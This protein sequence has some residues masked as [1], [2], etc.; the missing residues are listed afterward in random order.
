[1]GELGGMR[2]G[3]GPEAVAHTLSVTVK[4]GT[5]EAEASVS[6]A[7]PAAEFLPASRIVAVRDLLEEAMDAFAVDA[8]ECRVVVYLT[9]G[10]TTL[11][12]SLRTRLFDTGEEGGLVTHLL[13]ALGH[14]NL[15]L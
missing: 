2:E 11:S 3:L 5:V 14:I 1:M 8:E 7:A 13:D 6:W 15:A 4:R 9:S 12:V 10:A